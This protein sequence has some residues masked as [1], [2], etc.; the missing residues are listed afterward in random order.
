M[1]AMK[2]AMSRPRGRS[3]LSK[4]TARSLLAALYRRAEKG[5]CLAAESLLRLIIG[6]DCAQAKERELRETEAA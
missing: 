2:Q 3:P 4:R 6:R 1:T 5:D